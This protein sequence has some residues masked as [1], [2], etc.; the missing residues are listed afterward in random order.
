[1][2]AYNYL[3]EDSSTKSLNETLSTEE[4]NEFFE[5]VKNIK[6]KGELDECLLRIQQEITRLKDDLATNKGEN[7]FVTLSPANSQASIGEGDENNILSTE[8][9]STK[10]TSA[11]AEDSNGDTNG[12]YE[13]LNA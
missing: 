4:I 1:M 11:G 2:I 3:K 6:D 5:K 12:E 7:G 9:G 10:A 8:K 13:K